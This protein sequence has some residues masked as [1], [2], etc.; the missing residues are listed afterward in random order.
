MYDWKPAKEP[1]SKANQRFFLTDGFSILPQYS[2]ASPFAQLDHIWRPGISCVA[3]N[4]KGV[5]GE[6]LNHVVPFVICRFSS[7]YF[8][9]TTH[10][11]RQLEKTTDILY[12]HTSRVKKKKHH[13][14]S[15]VVVGGRMYF[16]IPALGRWWQEDWN[17]ETS[18]GYTVKPCPQI[19]FQKGV[20]E[21]LSRLKAFSV[22]LSAILRS[23]RETKLT[24]NASVLW[25]KC[26]R[27]QTY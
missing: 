10:I 23:H 18:L 13:A 27:A 22:H 20:V 24:P 15:G 25:L 16:V 5:W 4:S 19:F 14:D 6:D 8:P 2:L 3:Q 12:T 1:K 7:L 17:F 21:W 9:A 26:R 11:L